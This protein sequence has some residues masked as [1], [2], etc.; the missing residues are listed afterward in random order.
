MIKEI[1]V[2]KNI[3][4]DFVEWNGWG[5]P[6]S[7]FQIKEYTYRECESVGEVDLTTDVLTKWMNGE[8]EFQ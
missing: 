7:E 1:T 6:T 2:Y 5:P 8:I 3:M 4:R